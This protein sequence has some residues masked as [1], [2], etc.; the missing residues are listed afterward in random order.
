MII[1]THL[2]DYLKASGLQT[3]LL[4]NFGSHSVQFRRGMQS[5]GKGAGTQAVV[6]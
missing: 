6:T 5:P 2:E 1:I 4:I 3:G